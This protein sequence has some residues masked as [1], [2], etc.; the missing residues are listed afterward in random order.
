MLEQG[1]STHFD[2]KVLDAFLQ[3]LDEVLAIREE[4]KDDESDF[5]VAKTKE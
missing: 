2:P 3:G 5:A 4:L 1:R